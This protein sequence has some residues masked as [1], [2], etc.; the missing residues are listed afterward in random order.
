MQKL[1]C[2]FAESNPEAKVPPYKPRSGQNIALYASCTDKTSVSLF[3]QFK[4]V[5]SPLGTLKK[6]KKNQ[7]QN[8]TKQ[9]KTH[10]YLSVTISKSD[11]Y[12]WFT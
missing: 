2:L 12:S 3:T 10:R 6:K 9:N 11:L 4:F 5:T 7:K 8:K 1:K